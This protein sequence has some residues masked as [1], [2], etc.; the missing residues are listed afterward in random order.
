MWDRAGCLAIS[1][2]LNTPLA[3]IILCI[4]LVLAIVIAAM[5][6]FIRKSSSKSGDSFAGAGALATEV[7]SGIKTIAALCAEPWALLTYD[8]YVTDAQRSAVWGGFLAASSAGVTGLLF[9]TLVWLAH[10]LFNLVYYFCML[11]LFHLLKFYIHRLFGKHIHSLTHYMYVS[12]RY[13]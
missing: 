13:P 1:L 10:L 6:C 4:V 7:L 3:L 8:S 5:A 9:C 2:M 12:L 11:L